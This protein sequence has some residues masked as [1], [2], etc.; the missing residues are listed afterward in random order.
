MLATDRIRSLLAI[1]CN[2]WHLDAACQAEQVHLDPQSN[3]CRLA[4]CTHAV[5]TAVACNWGCATRAEWQGGRRAERQ[6]GRKAGR[7]R[8]ERQ[9]GREAD[10]TGHVHLVAQQTSRQCQLHM[11][12][13]ACE[14]VQRVMHMAMACAFECC[15]AKLLFM[16]SKILQHLACCLCYTEKVK[17]ETVGDTTRSCSCCLCCIYTC[18]YTCVHKHGDIDR[19][20]T[21]DIQGIYRH[22]ESAARS[23]H[24]AQSSLREAMMREAM[25]RE[26]TIREAT[27]PVN[28]APLCFCCPIPCTP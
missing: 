8:A 1:A 3:L 21:R 25:M 10:T 12:A 9:K 13:S 24:T 28:A 27:C 22:S 19:G 17:V 5:Q 23:Q 2:C 14:C 15:S 7:R 11:C 4:S 18:V 26:A 20:Y 6:K 16:I